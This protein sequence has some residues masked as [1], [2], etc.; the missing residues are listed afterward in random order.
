MPV[1]PVHDEFIIAGDLTFH[2]IQWGTQG[3]P[4]ICVHGITANAFYFQA[5]ADALASDHRVFAYDLRGRGDSDKPEQG[6]NIPI[7]AADLSELI[8]ELGLERPV[9]IGH[10]LGA[11]IALYFA[12]HYP[13]KLS[14]LVL[15]DAGT[16]LPWN[17]SD[18]RPTWLNLSF[19]RLGTPVASFQEYI[20][21]LKATPHLGPYWNEY[22]DIYFEHDVRRGSDGSVVAKAYR[23]AVLEDQ[24]YLEEDN[25]PDQQ[26]AHVQ[27]PTLFLR[28][29]QASISEGDQLVPEESAAA[30]R[31]AIKDCRYVNFPTLNHYTIILGVESGPALAIR[32]FI[33][34]GKIGL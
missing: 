3:T 16:P 14:K 15:I 32:S 31:Q 26:W 18:E 2:V 24:L 13:E 8:D 11:L 7:H 34:E 21:R 9:V 22:I 27:V 10:S 29:G 30:A 12:A 23:E 5:L 4:I 1:N 28:A 20:Q 19:N 17:T 25:R 33:D 6:Y